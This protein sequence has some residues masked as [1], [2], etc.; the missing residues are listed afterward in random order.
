MREIRAIARREF[1]E[2]Y[3]DTRFRWM[4]VVVFGALLVAFGAGWS[5]RAESARQRAAAAAEQRELWL[6]QGKKNPHGAAHFGY[7]AFRPELPTANLD[8][9]LD[10]YLGTVQFLEAHMRDVAAYRP[11]E[12]DGPARR[13]GEMTAAFTLQILLPLIII[14]LAYGAYA[15]ERETLRQTLSLGIAP[16][17]VA[18]GKALGAALPMLAIVVPAAALGALALTMSNGFG[19]LRDSLPRLVVLIAAYLAYLLLFVGVSIAVSARARSARAAAVIL[20]GFWG[21]NCLLAP[22]LVADTGASLHPIP[23][24]AEF[25]KAIR[26][27]AKGHGDWD[28]QV[29][30]KTR[31][32]MAKYGVDDPKKLPINPEA[33]MLADG[34]ENDTRAN[35][36]HFLALFERYD[37]Q[38]GFLERSGFVVPLVAI[39]AVSSGMTGT[40][41]AHHRHFSDAAEHYRRELV[42]TL[43]ADILAQGNSDKIW[44]YEADAALWSKIPPFSYQAPDWRWAAREIGFSLALLGGWLVAV[45]GA[46]WL[47]ARRPRLE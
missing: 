37:R 33:V 20:F 25:R 40:D 8:R 11:V 41:F 42:N 4:C 38:R 46:V 32:L 23:S 21:F 5:A 26:D 36:K 1:L 27:E 39:Q 47:S 3:R 34:E 17:R 9:G 31:Q 14:A 13:F 45:T 19:A 10:P 12:D 2:T 16:S 7:Y 44:D 35:E 6:N 28:A 18:V 22:R 15:G 29:A 30:E 43:N 24:A